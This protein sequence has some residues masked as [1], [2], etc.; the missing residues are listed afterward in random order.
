MLPLV[1]D[2]AVCIV[3]CCSILQTAAADAGWQDQIT[4]RPQTESG[5]IQGAAGRRGR[6]QSENQAADM[7][8]INSS[9]WHTI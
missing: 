4:K 7:N 6:D 3:L 8:L 9:T 1:D 5:R 2:K